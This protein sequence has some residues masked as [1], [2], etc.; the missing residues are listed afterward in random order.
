MSQSGMDKDIVKENIRVYGKWILAGEYSVLKGFPALAF[1]LPSRFMELNYEK[2]GSFFLK[3]PAHPPAGDKGALVSSEVSLRLHKVFALVLD[4]ALKN[5]SKTRADLKGLINFKSCILPGVGMGASAV[6][7]VLI[8]KLFYKLKWL[9][10]SEL[11]SFCHSL[12]NHL[13]GQSSG[14]DIAVVLTGKPV[15]F[16]TSSPPAGGA[17]PAGGGADEPSAGPAGEGVRKESSQIRV[18]CPKWRPFIF[19]SHSGAV[20]STKSNMKKIQLFWKQE[21]QKA[22]ALNRQMAQAVLKAERGFLT[23]NNREGLFL[24]TEAFSLAEEC[25]FKWG[26]TG[27][28]LKKHSALL[29]K[30]GAL[31]VKPTGSGAGGCVLSL[32]RAD[33]PSDLNLWPAF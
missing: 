11:F 10:K 26:L 31:A 3:K 18:F 17:P 21:P 7:C 5:I 13:H 29:K 6:I 30:R 9:K 15:R 4:Q 20:R 1:P 16:V 19:L 32:W 2:A 23:T 25:F 12:E 27:G 8:G 28:G 24:L 22:E 33:P 14:L